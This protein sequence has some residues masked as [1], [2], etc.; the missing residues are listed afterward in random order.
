[1]IFGHEKKLWW[2]MEFTTS[3][4]VSE[5]TVS[6]DL[7]RITRKKPEASS[8]LILNCGPRPSRSMS[9]FS[10]H[11][12]NSSVCPNDRPLKKESGLTAETMAFFP[13]TK[14]RTGVHADARPQ[15]WCGQKDF[16]LRLPPY[17]RGV[18]ST[19]LCP[20][21][22]RKCRLTPAL[23]QSEFELWIFFNIG[24]VA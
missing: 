13:R 15:N 1:M 3:I 12:S 20:H 11:H 17:E 7:G 5:N 2:A 8:N 10:T 22:N 14:K 6:F 19:E 4:S 24:C 9:T 16:N 21:K 23:Y 18:L